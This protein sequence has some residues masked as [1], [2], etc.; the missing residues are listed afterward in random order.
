MSDK[1]IVYT[2]VTYNIHISV[3]PSYEPDESNPAIG[4]FIYSYHVKIENFNNVRVKLLSRHWHIVDSIQVQREVSGEG[5]IGHQPE[6]DPGDHFEYTSWCPLHSPIGKMY[7]T[8]TFKNL[9]T[10]ELWSVEIPEFLLV[11]D[12]KLN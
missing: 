11:S 4:K 8:Y 1:T 6:L 2:K 5:V 7:G 10:G 9:D 3:L 12:F